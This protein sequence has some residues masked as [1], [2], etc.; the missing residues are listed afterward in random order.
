MHGCVRTCII[1]DGGGN[2]LFNAPQRRLATRCRQCKPAKA[3]RPRVEQPLAV[4]ARDSKLRASRYRLRQT[5]TTYA[6]AGGC[7][8]K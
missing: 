4:E 1:G 8:K 5:A 7:V 3:A 2:R 6:H